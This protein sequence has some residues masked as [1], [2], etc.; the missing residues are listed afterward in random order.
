[1]E[2][3]RL[4]WTNG[5]VTTGKSWTEVENSI[6][7]AQWNSYPTAL[8]FRRDMANR[9]KVW[10]RYD[11]GN[12]GRIMFMTSEQFVRGLEEAG[13]LRIVIEQSHNEGATS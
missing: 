9:A 2:V 7:A 1:M 5:S 4:L 12:A 13:M 3:I 11:M 10:S 8:S 6:R